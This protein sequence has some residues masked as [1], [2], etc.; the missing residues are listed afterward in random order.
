[1][2]KLGYT[3]A[4]AAK[5]SAVKPHVIETAI[6]EGRLV[7]KRIDGKAVIPRKA[8]TTWLNSCEDYVTSG[9]I[10]ESIRR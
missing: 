3:I 9:L 7:A 5:D 2:A 8:I 6:Q 10:P 1:M 4:Q